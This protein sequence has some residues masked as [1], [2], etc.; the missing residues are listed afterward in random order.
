MELLILQGLDP[1]GLNHISFVFDLGFR[2]LHFCDLSF[3]VE[4]F[5]SDKIGVGF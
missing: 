1:Q 2:D 3:F 4:V 5:N